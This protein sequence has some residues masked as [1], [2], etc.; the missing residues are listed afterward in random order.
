MIATDGRH[1]YS[2]VNEGVPSVAQHQKQMCYSDSRQRL[3]HPWP[4][5]HDTPK[6]KNG[7]LDSLGVAFKEKT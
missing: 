3:R 1:Q 2:G 5:M 4:Q 7:T 6:K